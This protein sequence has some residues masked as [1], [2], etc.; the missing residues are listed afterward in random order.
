M[1]SADGLAEISTVETMFDRGG[2]ENGGD[3][4]FGIQKKL[5]GRLWLC[6]WVLEV[7]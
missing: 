7:K 3:D 6:V 2:V 5:G 1:L 4:T